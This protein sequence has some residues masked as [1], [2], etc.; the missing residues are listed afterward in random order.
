M[1]TKVDCLGAFGFQ[2]RFQEG[3]VADL[4]IGIV[5]DILGHVAIEN[6]KGSRVEWIPPIG[7]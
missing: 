4:I 7:S 2:V 5:V 3:G 1:V 6:L